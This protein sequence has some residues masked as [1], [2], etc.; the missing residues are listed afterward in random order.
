MHIRYNPNNNLMN[1]ILQTGLASLYS[2]TNLTNYVLE[3]ML[4]LYIGA[5]EWTGGRLLVA[6]SC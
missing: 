1:A 2:T 4:L 6:K 5:E 3:S